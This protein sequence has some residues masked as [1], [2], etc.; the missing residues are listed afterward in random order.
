MYII[1]KILKRI[2]EILLSFKKIMIVFFD[3]H[4]NVYFL[5]QENTV[6]Y[7][8]NYSSNFPPGEISL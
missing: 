7:Y 1:D 5:D 4:E 6:F 3:I 2:T 8:L